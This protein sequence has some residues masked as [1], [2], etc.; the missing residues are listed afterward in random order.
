MAATTIKDGFEGG[1]DNQLKVNA[2]GSINVDSSGGGGTTNTA[3]DGLNSFQT[4][5]YAVGA[6]VVQIAPTPLTNRSS[7]TL[8]VDKNNVGAIYIGPDNT[9][10]ASTGYPLFAGDTLGMDLTSDGN[11]FAI[12][13]TPGQVLAA[14]EMA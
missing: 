8:R 14:L 3:L 12:S 2:D 5:Q 13:D 4:S 9:V 7:I 10:T 11:V 1:S 6:S